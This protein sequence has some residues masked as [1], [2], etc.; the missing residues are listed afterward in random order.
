MSDDQA[1]RAANLGYFFDASV[2]RTPDKTAIYDLYGGTERQVTYAMLDERADRVAGLLH[3]LGVRAGQRVGMVVGNRSEFLEIFFG[4]MR[5]GA[6]PVPINTR[7]ARDTLK[8]ILEDAE[9]AAVFVEPAA[10]PS[11]V[12]VAQAAGIVHRMHGGQ[13]PRRGQRRGLHEPVR[14]GLLLPDVLWRHGADG[15]PGGLLLR[16]GSVIGRH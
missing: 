10:H 4:T 15:V 12:E 9:C 16:R 14:G 13:L 3:G 11:A 7:L 6:I 8:F 1:N 5:T 2:A